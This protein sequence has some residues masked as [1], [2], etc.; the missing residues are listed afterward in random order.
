MLN[1]TPDDWALLNMVPQFQ[2]FMGQLRTE[3]MTVEGTMGTGAIL[4]ADNPYATA[5]NYALNCGRLMAIA[6]ILEYKPEQPE[7]GTSDR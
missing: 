2:Q 7:E 4:D 1:F 3:R 6:E 5:S